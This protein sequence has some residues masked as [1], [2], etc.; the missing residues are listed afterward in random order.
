MDLLIRRILAGK[1]DFYLPQ[2]DFMALFQQEVFTVG[3]FMTR[4]D[5]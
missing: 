5:L 1:S 4:D 2:S 3:Y